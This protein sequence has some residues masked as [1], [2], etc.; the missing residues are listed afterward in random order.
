M[1]SV[2]WG[3]WRNWRSSRRACVCRLLIEIAGGFLKVMGVYEGTSSVNVFLYVE[4][5]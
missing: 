3:D 2:F 4:F 5:L 1:C